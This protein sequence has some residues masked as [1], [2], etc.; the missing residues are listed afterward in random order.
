[1]LIKNRDDFRV[2][3]EINAK[4][5][6]VWRVKVGGKKGST[7]TSCNSLEEATENARQLNLDPWFAERGNTRKD[8]ADRY[9]DRKIK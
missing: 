7:V 6:T 9:P 3:E 4:G 5:I 1:M 2:F 8:R